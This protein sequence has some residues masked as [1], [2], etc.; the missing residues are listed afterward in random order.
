MQAYKKIISRNE[1]SQERKDERKS[2]FKNETKRSKLSIIDKS[3]TI[4]NNYS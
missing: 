4:N 3:I 1:T 2:E